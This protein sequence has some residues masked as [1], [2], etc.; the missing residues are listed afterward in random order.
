MEP[1]VTH[2]KAREWI[3]RLPERARADV[4]AGCKS[5]LQAMWD[6]IRWDVEHSTTGRDRE[7]GMSCWA[8]ADT[9]AD[10]IGST[11]R[12]VS[13]RQGKLAKAGWIK[14]DGRGWAMSWA[15]PFA[16][17]C[18]AQPRARRHRGVSASTPGCSA[19]ST[20]V[21]AGEHRGVTKRSNEPSKDPTDEPTPQRAPDVNSPGVSASPGCQ[22]CLGNGYVLGR[23]GPDA[24]WNPDM[25]R[26]LCIRCL[27]T[28]GE[29]PSPA[30]TQRAPAAPV[31]ER[32]PSPS[33]KARK[34]RPP[35]PKPGQ[36][37]L[38]LPDAPEADDVAELLALH[39]RLRG[40]AL[41]ADGRQA[42]PLPGKSSKHGRALRTG[43]RKA[44]ATH[45]AAVCRRV[46]V[47]QAARWVDDPSQLEWSTH[48]VWA[49]DS[50]AK[51]IGWSAG[52]AQ[53]RASPNKPRG[54]TLSCEPVPGEM[55][56]FVFDKNGE[57][58]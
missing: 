7:P 48:R 40:E 43:L 50:L 58:L 56:R 57:C 24:E 33:P 26:T 10:E 14:R 44:V 31:V 34:R 19:D 1:A 32:P 16:P 21:L 30:Q 49:V 36:T 22:R 25:S 8:S 27:G 47:W 55:T 11:E 13:D 20:V 12:A 6:H 29:P 46:I 38:D 18:R 5:V 23:P 45:G 37:G 42:T 4:D 53:A 52:Q 15:V 41:T 28:G 39:E 17:E 2:V 51:T 9:L 35:E 54:P 3:K